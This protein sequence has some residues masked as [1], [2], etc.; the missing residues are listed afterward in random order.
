[1]SVRQGGLPEVSFGTYR[2]KGDELSY[3]SI[4][5]AQVYKNEADV[6]AFL[7]EEFELGR[8]KRSEVFVTTKIAPSNQGEEKAYASVLESLQ[9]LNLEYI[10]LVLIHWPGSSGIKPTDP[11]NA[12]RRRGTW[13]SLER[14]TTEIVGDGP[15]VKFIGVELHPLHPQQPLKTFCTNHSIRVQAYSSLGEGNLVNPT[16]ISSMR[17][18]ATGE[19]LEDVL[20]GIVQRNPGTTIA[21]VLLGWSVGKGVAVI[22]KSRDGGRILENFLG[23]GVRLR[24]ED[25]KLLDELLTS[26]GFEGVKFC[27]DPEKIV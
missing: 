5:T 26:G 3:R 21:N 23:G 19:T 6:G 22:P 24:G 15:R 14:L 27:W 10:D 18:G 9:K 7:K 8:L 4:D 20:R 12:E 25:V 16:Y 1:M 11:R 13:K 2:L 17:S